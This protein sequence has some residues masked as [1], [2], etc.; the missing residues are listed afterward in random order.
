MSKILI[1]GGDGYLGWP[2]AMHF[3]AKGWDVCSIDNYAKR[4]ISSE[5]FSQPLIDFPEMDIRTRELKAS[6]GLNIEHVTGDLRDYDFIS[7][8]VK[9]FCPDTIV[10]YAEQPSAPYSM[11]NYRNAF[12]T[13]QKRD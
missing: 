6:L 11:Q 7:E 8:I 4:R 2:T 1:L 9:D 12:F 10:H 5:S 3:A 13:L